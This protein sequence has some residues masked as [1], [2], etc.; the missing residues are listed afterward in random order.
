[1]KCSSNLTIIRTRRL[2]KPDGIVRRCL[3]TCDIKKKAVINS[4]T[5]KK[6]WH[7]TTWSVL[8]INNNS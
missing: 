3:V 2:K 7:I 4:Y 8:G 1:M 5:E 6:V